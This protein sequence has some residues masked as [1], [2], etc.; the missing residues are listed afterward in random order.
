MWRDELKKAWD[1]NPVATIAT[2]AL[3]VTALAKIVDAISAT[4]GRRAYAKQ[5]KYRIKHSK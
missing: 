4:R 1:E 2:G 3:A 5:V